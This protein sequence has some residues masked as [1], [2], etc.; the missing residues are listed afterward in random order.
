MISKGGGCLIILPPLRIQETKVDEF[1]HMQVVSKVQKIGN[2]DTIQ[3]VEANKQQ[4]IFNAYLNDF[5]CNI[6]CAD[7]VKFFLCLL[8]YGLLIKISF[9]QRKY[10][11]LSFFACACNAKSFSIAF[12][13]FR[14][15]ASRQFFRNGL[16]KNVLPVLHHLLPQK[17]VTRIELIS[18]DTLA[19][20]FIKF[21]VIIIFR[22]C[23]H[24][25]LC[26]SEMSSNYGIKRA[27]GVL[28][29]NL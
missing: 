4:L 29:L 18:L 22:V 13:F 9:L 2:K 26:T 19:N 17:L 16:V 14:F 12:L 21:P 6:L 20:I 28:L 5:K 8:A 1:K 7:T 27:C 15:F 25:M 24:D 10:M 3:K 23:E 11:E